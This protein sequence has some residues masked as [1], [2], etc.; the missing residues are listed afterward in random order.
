VGDRFTSRWFT[1]ANWTLVEQMTQI[2]GEVGISLSHLTLAWV[3]AKPGVA[4]AIVGAS[5]PE[6]VVENARACEVKLSPEVI[7]QIDAISAHN[8]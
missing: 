4:S 6:Q 7:A 5:R 1:E 2:A 3:M 8:R